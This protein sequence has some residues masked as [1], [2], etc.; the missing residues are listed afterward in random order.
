MEGIKKAGL[1][2]RQ[3]ENNMFN[4]GKSKADFIYGGSVK[5]PFGSK[6]SHYLY[7]GIY[8]CVYTEHRGAG[9][10]LR[11]LSVCDRKGFPFPTKQDYDE[12]LDF[13]DMKCYEETLD[14]PHPVGK[15]RYFFK[16]IA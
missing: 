15:S 11:V 10:S 9:E 13:F 2:L 7:K 3:K 8:G 4:T 16:T 5:N 12:I 1:R 6:T 14:V